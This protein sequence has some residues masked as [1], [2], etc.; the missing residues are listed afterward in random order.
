M[1]SRLAYLVFVCVLF[2]GCDTL[3]DPE[4]VFL[5]VEIDE[6]CFEVDRLQNGILVSVLS[7]ANTVLDIGPALARDNLS[8]DDVIGARL[9]DAN[10]RLIFPVESNLTIIEDAELNLIGSSGARQVAALATFPASRNASLTPSSTDVSS[11]V[12]AA[13]FQ[14]SLQFDG[15]SDVNE[16]VVIEGSITIEVE[17]QDI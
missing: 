11:I 6:I 4:S 2:S 10:L 1:K 17:V 9:T 12:R 5:S 7:D 15:A 14:A 3:T 8:K 13:S 16:R